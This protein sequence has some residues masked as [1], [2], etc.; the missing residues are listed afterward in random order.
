MEMAIEGHW[1]AADLARRRGDLPGARDEALTGVNHAEACG[2]GLLRVELL[3]LLA[4]VQLAWPD[5]RVALQHARHALDL[6]TAPECGYAW[7]E[8]DAAQL[9]GEAH[10]ALGEPEQA[11]RRFEQALAVRERIEHPAVAETRAALARL[12]PS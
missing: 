2:F 10:L 3:G 4:R 1:I 11:R 12:T 8:A 7:G 5:A 9:C 6:A